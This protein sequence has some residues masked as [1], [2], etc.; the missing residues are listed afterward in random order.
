M[1]RKST[2]KTIKLLRKQLL[3]TAVCVACST[4]CFSQIE[5]TGGPYYLDHSVC[6]MPKVFDINNEQISIPSALNVFGEARGALCS[7]INVIYNG[8]DSNPQAQAAFQY[9]V[10]IW[11]QTLT[12][13]VPITINANFTDALPSGTLG[14][15]GPTGFFSLSGGLANTVYPR[16]LAEKI[17]G[18]EIG[19]ANSIDISCNFNSQVN[20]YYGTNANPPNSQFDFVSVVLHELGHGLGFLGFGTIS[21][22][23]GTILNS[24]SLSPYDNYTETGSGNALTIFPNNSGFLADALRSGDL[25]INSPLATAANGGVKPQIWA[26][27]TFNGGSSYSHWDNN[28]FPNSNV[29]SLMTPSIGNGQ[30]NHNTG[31]ITRALFEE[32]GWTVC[33]SLSVAESTLESLSVSPNPFN[34]AIRITLPN[35]LSDRDFNISIFDINGR[36][37]FE[38][39]TNSTNNMIDLDISQLKTSMYFMQVEDAASG[40]SITK[41]IVKQ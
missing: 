21:N 25:F 23:E 14:S 3:L 15:A 26:P 10:D 13:S 37:V 32:F 36:I 39:Q 12:S 6:E 19:G 30:A 41:K 7:T 27:S 34:D 35:N 24:G 38:K 29:N 1:K 20:W 8:F 2:L 40:V 5:V 33:N 18:A 9:A 31:P 28:V 17:T 22:G 16:A 4:F 11:A